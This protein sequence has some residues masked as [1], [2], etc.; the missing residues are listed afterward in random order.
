VRRPGRNHAGEPVPRPAAYSPARPAQQLKVGHSH[1]MQECTPTAAGAG[2]TITVV[3]STMPPRGSDNDVVPTK[4]TTG[5]GRTCRARSHGRWRFVAAWRRE[6]GGS[7][8]SGGISVETLV[9]QPVGGMVGLLSTR[10]RV[11]SRTTTRLE[12]RVHGSAAH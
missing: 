10:K 7:S 4:R 3:Q 8:T 5:V 2:M 12:E 6:G 9:R 11:R 1:T